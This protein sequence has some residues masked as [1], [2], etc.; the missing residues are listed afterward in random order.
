MD[1][2][3]SWTSALGNAYVNQP[4]AV[5]DAVQV[6]RARAEAAGNLQSNQQETVATEGQT[7]TIE[8]ADPEVVYIPAYDPWIVYGVPLVAWPGW[9]A[10]PG[11]YVATPGISFGVGF[12]IGF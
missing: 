11:L 1:K 4:E 2:N 7:I 3:L 9:Y 5:M 10:Y 8:P 6:M 12:A